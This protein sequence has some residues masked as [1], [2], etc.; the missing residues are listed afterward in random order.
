VL[1]RWHPSSRS[2]FARP[3][4]LAG[5]SA[6]EVID[7]NDRTAHFNLQ[8]RGAA[9]RFGHGKVTHLARAFVGD[10]CGQSLFGY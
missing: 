2:V 8:D 5:A 10:H 6:D 1:L 3:G 4:D 9:G 7:F